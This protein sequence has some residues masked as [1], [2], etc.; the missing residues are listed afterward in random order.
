MNALQTYSGILQLTETSIPASTNEA[1]VR[2]IKSGLCGT[3][4][5]IVRGYAGFEGTIGHE[6]VGIVE[7]SETMPELI[8]KRVVGEINVGCKTCAV[9]LTG[10]ERHC[11]HRTVLGIHGRNGAHADFLTLPGSN[12]IEVPGNVSD[13]AAV[14]T[15]PLA[16]AYGITERVKIESSTSVAVVGD[17]RLGLLT[18]FALSTETQELTLIGKH[19]EKLGMAARRGIK[20]LVLDEMSKMKGD[21]DVAVDATGSPS[22]LAT[23]LSLV[24]PLGTVVL[25]TTFH[26]FT[27]WNSTRAVVDEI[28][29]VGSRCGRFLPALELLST[30]R[31]VVDDLVSEEFPLTAGVEAVRRAGEKGV[32]KV[33]I[34]MGVGN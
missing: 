5:E 32:I 29:I 4:L 15:E 25:K 18:A 21:F 17:G 16:A 27:E 6:F 20:T 11:P 28:T 26:G 3:D 9:C 31:V 22:G 7:R 1:L 13:T 14:F 30:R 34:D 8:G 10:D 33:L 24:R 19:E 2:V 23:A 12:L